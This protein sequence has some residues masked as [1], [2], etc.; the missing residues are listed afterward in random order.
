VA[1][2]GSHCS[3]I[4]SKGALDLSSSSCPCSK[5]DSPLFILISG[6]VLY[7][8]MSEITVY[9]FQI[10]ISLDLSTPRGWVRVC[11]RYRSCNLYLYLYRTLYHTSRRY[12]LTPGDPYQHPFF[13]PKVLLNMVNFCVLHP[14]NLFQ[15]HKHNSTRE[16][17]LIP[18]LKEQEAKYFQ[19]GKYCTT[20]F[21]RG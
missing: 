18:L 10:Y 12:T 11:Q 4:P 19:I 15:A 16:S 9:T 14:E 20:R 1:S 17:I 7:S 8:K 13:E 6:Q 3:E 21:A 5:A 2:W